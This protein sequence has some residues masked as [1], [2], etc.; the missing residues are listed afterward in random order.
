MFLGEIFVCA[1]PKLTGDCNSNLERFYY[2]S[3][4]KKCIPFMYSG[5]GGK[6]KL[7]YCEFFY[8]NLF[9]KFI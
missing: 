7:K 8:E 3:F 4:L 2:D 5:C 9:I 6:I 1:Q